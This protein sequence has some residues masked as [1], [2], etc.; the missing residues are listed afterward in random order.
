MVYPG[1]Y[2]CGDAVRDELEGCD[3]A[4]WECLSDCTGYAWAAEGTADDYAPG[5]GGGVEGKGSMV[6]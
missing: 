1:D 3:S 6:S 5:G 2:V 4:E